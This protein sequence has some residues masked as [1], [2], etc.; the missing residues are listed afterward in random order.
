MLDEFHHKSCKRV[1]EKLR[2]RIYEELRAKAESSDLLEDL[3]NLVPC[4]G[5]WVIKNSAD[6]C[7]VLNWSVEVEFVDSILIWHIATEIIYQITIKDVAKMTTDDHRNAN[8]NE[9]K[10]SKLLSD[11]VFYLMVMQPN[12]MPSMGR[13]MVKYQETCQDVEAYFCPDKFETR[14]T[15]EER[16]ETLVSEVEPLAHGNNSMFWKAVQLAKELNELDISYRWSLMSSVWVEILGYAASHC[17]GYAHA[18]QLSKG[19]ELLTFVWLLMAH[20]GIIRDYVE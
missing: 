6:Y 18:Q 10:T 20:L 5:Q 7:Q 4:R 11:Y 14:Q 12:T 3:K 1:T 8:G 2:I 9:R 16:C 17:R 19:G 13:W 15:L